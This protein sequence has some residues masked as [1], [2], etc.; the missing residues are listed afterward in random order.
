MRTCWHTRTLPEAPSWGRGRDKEGEPGAKWWTGGSSVDW[1]GSDTD[2]RTMSRLT[3][4]KFSL[5][6]SRDYVKGASSRSKALRTSS[7]YNDVCLPLLSSSSIAGQ[8]AVIWTFKHLEE[9]TRWF[10]R[11]LRNALCIFR[12][13]SEKAGVVSNCGVLHEMKPRSRGFFLL[14]TLGNQLASSTIRACKSSDA[15]LKA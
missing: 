14:S 9:A 10:M 5:C 11:R 1:W 7:S 6:E 3:M 12:D 2:V 13:A 8:P 15:Y 4:G